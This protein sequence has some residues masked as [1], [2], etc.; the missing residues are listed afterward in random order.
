MDPH[1]WE[2]TLGLRPKRAPSGGPRRFFSGMVGLA[3]GQTARLNVVNVGDR[4][5]VV[6]K[7]TVGNPMSE[8]IAESE[9]VLEPGESAY[10][11]VPYAS[12][13]SREEKRH[14]IRA[15]VT[16]LEPADA[17]CLVTFEVFDAETGRTIVCHAVPESE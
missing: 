17:R 15:V 16:V 9:S 13:A 2:V 1:E 7:G 11:D 10:L 12:V 5:V 6:R 4:K 3:R 14:Q 8:P